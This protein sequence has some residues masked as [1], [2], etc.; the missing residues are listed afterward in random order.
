MVEKGSHLLLFAGAGAAPE[1]GLGV[2]LVVLLAHIRVEL[3]LIIE[4]D[5]VIV[6]VVQHVLAR[7]IFPPNL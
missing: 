5:A 6:H 4:E 2:V 1:D 7:A 3:P